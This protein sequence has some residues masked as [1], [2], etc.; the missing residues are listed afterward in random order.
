MIAAIAWA[1]VIWLVMLLAYGPDTL[2][3][4]RAKRSRQGDRRLD[5]TSR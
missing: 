2:K 3:A 4:I 1:L 5:P